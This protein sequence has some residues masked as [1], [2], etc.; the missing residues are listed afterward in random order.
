MGMVF[1]AIQFMR[2]NNLLFWIISISIPVAMFL[3]A[4]GIYLNKDK[5]K[6]LKLFF[7]L[8][9][10]FTLFYFVMAHWLPLILII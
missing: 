2:L 7:K 6:E 8:E 4:L 1:I 10:G 9:L 3:M 5:H